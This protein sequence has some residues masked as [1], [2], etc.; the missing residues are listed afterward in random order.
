M[1][2][3]TVFSFVAEANSYLFDRL[4]HYTHAH[5]NRHA[6]AQS[7]VRSEI[8]GT[9]D[10]YIYRSRLN[11]VIDIVNQPEVIM[12][13]DTFGVCYVVVPIII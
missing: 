13:V 10:I 11:H 3:K 12:F 7:I 2:N 1:S 6:R 9:M 4:G 5:T 8:N